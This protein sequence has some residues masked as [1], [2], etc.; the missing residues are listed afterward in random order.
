M[1]SLLYDYNSQSLTIWGITIAIAFAIMVVGVCRNIV[2]L[3]TRHRDQIARVRQLL[4]SNMLERL[5]ISF[6]R[7]DR[8]TSDMDKERHIWACEHCPKPGECERMLLG[9]DIDPNTFCPN[10]LRLKQ[11]K[12][13][14]NGV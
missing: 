2:F 4:L 7:Y 6:N 8:M 5:N 10:Y 14:L 11:L 9:E 12:E 3:H 13:N 1:D